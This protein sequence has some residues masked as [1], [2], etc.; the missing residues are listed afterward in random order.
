MKPGR[1]SPQVIL[2]AG[3]SG[4]GK[5]ALAC[6]LVKALGEQRCGRLA[7]DDYYLD[8]VETPSARRS[9]INF[10]HPSA[11]DWEFF[12]KHLDSLSAGRFIEKP[13]YDFTSH[14]RS[15]RT[16]IVHPLPIIVVDGIHA[17]GNDAI[18]KLAHLKVY[19]HGSREVCLARRLQR[20]VLERGRSEASVRKQFNETVWPMAEQFVLSKQG[21]ADIVVYGEQSIGDGVGIVLEQIS[22]E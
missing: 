6:A 14:T 19:V 21:E 4:A 7:L 1:N 9:T 13:C 10:D 8:R 15:A 12:L 11:I 3:P 17:M 22:A 20:D 16:E 5:S 2:V 18:V